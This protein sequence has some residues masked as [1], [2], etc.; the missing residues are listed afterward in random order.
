MYLFS[1]KGPRPTTDT[2]LYFPT[3]SYLLLNF[4]RFCLVCLCTV[5]W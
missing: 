4:G 2:L 1:T 3:T 5:K